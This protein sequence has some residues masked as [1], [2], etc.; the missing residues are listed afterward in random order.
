M[1]VI[2]VSISLFIFLWGCRDDHN[3]PRP[4]AYPRV[5]YPQH[6]LQPFS[7]EDC[8]FTFQFPKYA[9]V[10]QKE[11]HTCWFDISMPV[12]KAKLH[13]SYLQVKDR[14]HFDDMV[15]DTYTI[16]G[17]INE[18]SNYM[19]ESRIKNANGVGGLMLKFTGPAASPLH[20]FLT[21]TTQHFFKA[22]L[23]FEA[24]VKPDSLAPI[25]EFVESDINK[26]L[27][28]FQWSR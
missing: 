3:T 15:N 17:K 8:P 19:E 5:E 23:Y 6:E 7:Q 14:A 21:D 2:L 10:Q 22:S 24:K 25:I 16:A 1:R 11:D 26:M 4:R 20:F 18:R 28:S 27:D 9:E 12:F 13:C